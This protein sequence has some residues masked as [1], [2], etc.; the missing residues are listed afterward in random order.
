MASIITRK[1]IYD[2]LHIKISTRNHVFAL[3]RVHERVKAPLWRMADARAPIEES[4]LRWY[5]YYE[6]SSDIRLPHRS[7]VVP[8]VVL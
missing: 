2:S 8:Q 4:Q 3:I 5:Y 7:T 6:R 1:Y